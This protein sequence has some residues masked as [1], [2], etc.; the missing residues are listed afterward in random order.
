MKKREYVY[1]F[2]IAICLATAGYFIKGSSAQ[3]AIPAKTFDYQIGA[4]LYQQKA[5]EYRALAYQAFIIA[6]ERLDEDKKSA[7]KLPKSER[8]RP[9]AV[10][11]DI[12]ETV[13]DNSPSNAYI[14]LNNL[15]FN[16]RDWYAWSEMRKAK[17]VPGAVDFINYAVDQGV[18]IYYISN[19]DEVQKQATIDNLRGVGFKDVSDE[20]VM[21]RKTESAKGPRRQIVAAKYRVVFLMGDNLDDFSE[22]YERKSTAERFAGVDRDRF[23]FGKRFI[24]LPNAM[25]GTWESA[26]Y[27]YERLTESQKAERRV[28]ALELP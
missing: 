3:Q 26:L 20:N 16:T 4:I 25:Y 23:E 8:K 1:L 11:V 7:K 13:L 2:S 28:N 6:R 17:P 10:I 21:L 5:A 14:A 9:R 27:N 18:K 19:R 24:A 12:D 15:P 22:I